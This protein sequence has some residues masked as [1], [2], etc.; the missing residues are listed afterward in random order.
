MA[1]RGAFP[2]G[3]RQQLVG[4]VRE[5]DVPVV[6]AAQMFGVSR[7]TAHKWLKR[8]KARGVE[9][10]V[11]LS[12]A[13]HSVDRFE[14]PA[15]EALVELRRRFPRWGPRKLLDYLATSSPALELPAVSTA[16]ALLKRMGLVT[17]RPARRRRGTTPYQVS[18]SVP[19]EPNDRWTVDFKGEF[20][21][22]NG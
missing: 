21:L 11:D 5:R 15:V 7:K 4:L 12:R 8:A 1:W 20:R 3:E 9:G 2:V 14:G 22:G 10:L 18:A 17:P 16:G 19:H 13:R 6:E